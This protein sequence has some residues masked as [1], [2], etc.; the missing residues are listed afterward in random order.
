MASKHGVP[1]IRTWFVS[2]RYRPHA[3]VSQVD[4]S[5]LM[6]RNRK[7]LN[8]TLRLLQPPGPAEH[9]AFTSK[10][11]RQHPTNGRVANA[12]CRIGVTLS[13]RHPS[14]LPGP[15]RQ[16][17][18]DCRRRTTYARSAD[19]YSESVRR[20]HPSGP[21]RTIHVTA[22]RVVSTFERAG[23]AVGPATPN[24]VRA[25]AECPFWIALAKSFVN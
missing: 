7:G 22:S 3:A 9:N 17:K 20:S 19:R 14:R 25:S 13:S 8:S 15:A 18:H 11:E 21:E 5:S 12:H 4:D 1:H 23:P 16:R 10:A 6:R 2:Q 24:S